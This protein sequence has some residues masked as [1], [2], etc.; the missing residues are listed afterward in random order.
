MEG[1]CVALV[2][3]AVPDVLTL[4]ADVGDEASRNAYQ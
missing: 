1:T 4:A 3:L 2:A